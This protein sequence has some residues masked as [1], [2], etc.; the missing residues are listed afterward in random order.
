MKGI[1]QPATLPSE[2]RGRSEALSHWYHETSKYTILE[3]QKLKM[4][5]TYM[6]W[7]CTEGLSE[8]SW[9][10]QLS[11]IPS[12]DSLSSTSSFQLFIY[13]RAPSHFGPWPSLMARHQS[14]EGKRGLTLILQSVEPECYIL[15]SHAPERHANVLLVVCKEKNFSLLALLITWPLLEVQSYFKNR[16]RYRYGYPIKITVP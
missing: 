8:S 15:F 11:T 4:F 14:E 16:I 1:E 7:K 9:R 6:K 2:C 3:G 10:T 12:S 5:V 13:S